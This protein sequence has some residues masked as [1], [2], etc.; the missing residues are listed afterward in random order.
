MHILIW[1]CCSWVKD[2]WRACHGLLLRLR[3]YMGLWGLCLW[4]SLRLGL[5]LRLLLL[6]LQWYRALRL[7]LCLDG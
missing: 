6:L 4:L 1:V 5:R 3:L 7:R 2:K